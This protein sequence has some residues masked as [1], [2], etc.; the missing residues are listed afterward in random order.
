MT[1]M[2]TLTS[3]FTVGAASA[4]IVNTSTKAVDAQCSM[5]F[6]YSANVPNG[7][8]WYGI[9]QSID[10]INFSNP[11][12]GTDASVTLVQAP[13]LP[14]NF[15]PGPGGSLYFPGSGIAY[16]ISQNL[17][18]F[19]TT[20]TVYTPITSVA[21]CLGCPN[22]MPQQWGVFTLNSSGNAYASQ[23]STYWTITYTNT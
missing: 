16:A 5:K 11:W 8:I 2:A 23:A 10:S 13:Q 21:S 20:P 17:A 15:T 3:S 6:V 1:S 19:A 4:A 14:T 22:V 12:A 18:G 9:C 7:L